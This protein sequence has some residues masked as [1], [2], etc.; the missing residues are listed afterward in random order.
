[1]IRNNPNDDP[2]KTNRTFTSCGNSY[3]QILVD[4]WIIEE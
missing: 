1:M 4:N 2:E 3:D